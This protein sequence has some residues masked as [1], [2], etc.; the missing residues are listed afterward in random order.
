MIKPLKIR[1]PR[2]LIPALL[3][4]AATGAQAQI[5]TIEGTIT[6]G[7]A[8]IDGATVAISHPATG[9]VLATG[10]TEPDG[11]Y[12]IEVEMEA[13]ATLDLVVEAAS[14]DH[15]PA[16]HG[17]S[18]SERLPTAATQPRWPFP[19]APITCWLNRLSTPLTP[20]ATQITT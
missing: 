12:S 1:I 10:Q 9:R 3:A 13:G 16:R 11:T 19:R 14:P 6:D 8:G 18:G 5:A 15:A 17:W 20:P 2:T 4:L 7:S